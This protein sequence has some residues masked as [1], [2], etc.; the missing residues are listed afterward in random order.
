MRKFLVGR[1][2]IQDRL[3]A[4]R[5]QVDGRARFLRARGQVKPRGAKRKMSNYTLRVR[6][7]LS[8]EVHQWVP[9]IQPT[10]P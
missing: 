6:G 8:R 5:Q 7:P 1:A 9:H 2:G 3:S 4:F 10:F